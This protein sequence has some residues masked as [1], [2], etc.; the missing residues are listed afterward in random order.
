MI[1]DN[2]TRP[3]IYLYQTMT[4]TSFPANFNHRNDVKSARDMY[5]IMTGLNPDN[6]FVI[7]T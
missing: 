6:L 3:A 1:I 5:T 4:C 7:P 2:K